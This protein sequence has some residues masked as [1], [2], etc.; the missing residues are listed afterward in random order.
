[1]AILLALVSAMAYGVSDFIGGIVSRRVSA[2]SVAVVGNTSATVCVALVALAVPGDPSGRD[3]AWAALAGV[4]TGLG[5]GFLYRGFASGRMSVVA[6][7]SA[8]GAAVVPVLAGAVGGERFAP[9]VWFGIAAA[10]PG[11]WL[12]ASVPEEHRTGPRASLAEGLVDGLL[13]GLGFGVLFA[14]LG[15]VP[16]GAGLWPL[17]AAQGVSVPTVVVLALLL[18]GSWVP[19]ERPVR[20]A[21]LAGLLGALATWSFLVS[22]QLGYL[23]ISGIL[24]SLYPATTVLLAALVLHERVHRAQGVGLGLCA[25]AVALVAAG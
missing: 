22:T 24:A 12:V 10:L 2:W 11:I 14:A 1:M 15:Q 19:R 4:A 21:V 8:V 13:A 18:R 20:W 16:D 17:A 6:P 25:V 5:T 7:I 3:F 9:L 23:T